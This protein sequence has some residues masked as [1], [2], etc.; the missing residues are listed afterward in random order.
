MAIPREISSAVADACR[1][2]G[3][4]ATLAQLIVAWFDEVASGN[5]QLTDVRAWERRVSLLL[6]AVEAPDAAEDGK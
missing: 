5:E 3:Q 4:S 1:A 6:E 2:A